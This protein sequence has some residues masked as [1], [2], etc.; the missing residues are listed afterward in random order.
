MGADVAG[1]V[2]GHVLDAT[3]RGRVV[4][5]ERDGEAEFVGEPIGD[6]VQEQH[7]QHRAD[8]ARLVRVEVTRTEVVQGVQHDH[9]GDAVGLVLT[10]PAD[11]PGVERADGCVGVGA[12]PGVDEV[13][14]EQVREFVGEHELGGAAGQQA[15]QGEALAGQLGQPPRLD[16]AVAVE[17]GVERLGQRVG[18][19]VRGQ[20]GR[21]AVGRRRPGHDLQHGVEQVQQGRVDQD[22]DAAA[23]HGDGEPVEGAGGEHAREDRCV[24]GQPGGPGQVQ[25]LGLQGVQRA[26]PVVQ[27]RGPVGGGPDADLGQAGEPGGERFGGH[28]GPR[29]VAR[30][31]VGRVRPRVE[32]VDHPPVPQQPDVPVPQVLDRHRAAFPHRG[33]WPQRGGPGGRSATTTLPDQRQHPPP[34]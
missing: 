31:G 5:R 14:G 20:Q 3:H 23:G 30:C 8:Q 22:E 11:G 6:L 26:L 32:V 29:V 18:R 1:E 25:H 34:A 12:A 21:C 10:G 28:P 2:V 15:G 19:L 4:A 17:V 7:Q 33:W 16:R 9:G 24:D 27:V 13:P